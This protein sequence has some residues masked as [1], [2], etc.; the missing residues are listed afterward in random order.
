MRSMG[1]LRLIERRLGINV[2]CAFCGGLGSSEF[3]L[4]DDE[5]QVV[6]P[7]GCPGCG[8]CA[9]GIKIIL[10]LDEPAVA[11]GVR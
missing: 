6:E 9:G 11:G 5:H 7:R 1:R 3:V 8:K 2:A 10:E 4:V